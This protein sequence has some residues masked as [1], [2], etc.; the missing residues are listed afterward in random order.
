[1][2]C[3][4]KELVEP[5]AQLFQQRILY[6]RL[7]HV[8][9]VAFRQHLLHRLPLLRVVHRNCGRGVGLSQV[10]SQS[11][12]GGL[13]ELSRGRRR[14]QRA[15]IGLLAAR[16]FGF[17]LAGILIFL[18]GLRQQHPQPPKAHQPLLCICSKRNAIIRSHQ[19]GVAGFC[20]P[21]L[22]ACI[23]Q[24]GQVLQMRAVLIQ[25]S[26]VRTVCSGSRQVGNSSS[27]VRRRYGKN[28]R[29]CNP[30]ESRSDHQA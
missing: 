15:L 27:G 22:G 7:V 5:V 17:W 9:E 20:V 10:L 2:R 14:W 1:M 11:R 12:F 28:S 21:R 23:H 4:F 26:I 25:R 30:S 24:C 6:R 29:Q 3:A 16:R 18:L 19:C 8:A 13:Q